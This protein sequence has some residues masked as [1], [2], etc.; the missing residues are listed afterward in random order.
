M[1]HLRSF[2]VLAVIIFYDNGSPTG[3]QIIKFLQNKKSV[4]FVPQLRRDDYKRVI[5]CHG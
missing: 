2:E 1:K 5:Y 3:L 4:G